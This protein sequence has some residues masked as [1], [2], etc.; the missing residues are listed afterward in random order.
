MG[1]EYTITMRK[2][3]SL[4]GTLAIGLALSHEVQ[5]QA[6]ERTCNETRT[7]SKGNFD[8][9]TKRII[10]KVNERVKTYGGGLEWIA[11][12]FDIRGQEARCGGLAKAVCEEGSYLGFESK[13]HLEMNTCGLHYYAVLMREGRSV[14]IDGRPLEVRA[15]RE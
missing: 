4:I 2:V 8:T 5:K 7:K 3:L 10:D 11:G 13:I 9:D 15:S 1:L 14:R 6:I 12:D